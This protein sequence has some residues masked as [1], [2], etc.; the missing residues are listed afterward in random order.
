VNS[1]AGLKARI[2]LYLKEV[3]E[4]LVVFKWKYKL[5]ELDTEASVVRNCNT[6]RLRKN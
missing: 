1:K 3:N 2:E 5:E 6:S 4:E